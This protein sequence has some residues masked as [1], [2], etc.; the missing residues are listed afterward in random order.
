MQVINVHAL[1]SDVNYINAVLVLMLACF[2]NNGLDVEKSRLSIIRDHN[3]F[4]EHFFFMQYIKYCA[5]SL[6]STGIT[7]SLSSYKSPI[8]FV[9]ERQAF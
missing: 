1:S 6:C 7:L 5:I 4:M 9:G 2:G 3:V 8:Q